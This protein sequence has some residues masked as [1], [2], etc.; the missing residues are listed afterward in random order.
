M[1]NYR[2]PPMNSRVYLNIPYSERKEAIE[3]KC[4]WDPFRKL[5]FCI[6]SDRGKNNVSECIKKWN[7]PEPYKI[8]YNRVTPL[9]EIP[10]NK[11]GY[12]I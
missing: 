6:D 4:R 5:W 7:N 12:T 10:K 9:H 1:S 3:L 2:E 11:R 8:L